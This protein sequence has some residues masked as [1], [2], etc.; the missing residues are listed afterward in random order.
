MLSWYSVREIKAH[1]VVLQDNDQSGRALDTTPCTRSAWRGVCAALEHQQ[2]ARSTWKCV[3][4]R[5]KEIAKK[6]I[7][8]LQCEETAV[9][10]FGEMQT[11]VDSMHKPRAWPEA[12]AR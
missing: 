9:R 3:L 6:S 8:R 11:E 5:N 12:A 1:E 4:R 7:R 2:S 10:S